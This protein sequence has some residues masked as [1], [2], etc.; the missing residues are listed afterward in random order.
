MLHNFQISSSLSTLVGR[1]GELPPSSLC[2]PRQPSDPPPS[3]Q[4]S[5]LLEGCSTS[6]ARMGGDG[7]ATGGCR[8][9]HNARYLTT[10]Q[11]AAGRL[12]PP[13][14]SYLPPPGLLPRV[15][16]QRWLGEG[17]VRHARRPG[18]ADNHSQNPFSACS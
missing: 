12:P 14:L 10:T 9:Q 5:P 16:G 15:R 7:S 18:K 4:L 8:Q 1:G 11:S 2:Y 3:H 13:P 6:R 17:A